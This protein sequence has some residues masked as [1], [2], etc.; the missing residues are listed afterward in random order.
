LKIREK[1]M[2]GGMGMGENYLILFFFLF[3]FILKLPCTPLLG[4]SSVSSNVALVGDWV[5]LGMVAKGKKG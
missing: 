1:K 3:P 2:Q 5:P 4:V